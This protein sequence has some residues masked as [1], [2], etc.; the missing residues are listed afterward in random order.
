MARETLK[1]MMNGVP[2]DGRPKLVANNTVRYMSG[3]RE[4]VRLHQTDIVTKHP[5]GTYELSTGG[6][7][8]RT[9]QDR[10]N[11]FSP[12]RIYSKS[13]SWYLAPNVPYHDGV[14]IGPNG[15]LPAGKLKIADKEQKLRKQ[16]REFIAKLDGMASLPVPGP[17]DC[18]ICS[19]F[20]CEPVS[21]QGPRC[22]ETT[23]PAENVDHLREHIKEGYLHGSLILNALAWSGYRDPGLIFHVENTNMTRGRKPDM[24]KRSLRR[25]LYRK[26]GLAT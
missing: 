21:V 22:V 10:L 19:M 3:G 6:W 18:W 15:E 23:G 7:K 26:L 12:A 4:I 11:R 25:Y 5:D 20:Q 17:G 2:H 9:T 8:T 1:A 16:I 14:R 24:V 13:G